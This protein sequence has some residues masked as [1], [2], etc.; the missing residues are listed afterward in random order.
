MELKMAKRKTDM[1]KQV[2]EL[3][4]LQLLLVK[5][6]N[7]YYNTAAK[8]YSMSTRMYNWVDTYNDMKSLPAWSVFRKKHG[9]DVGHDAFDNFA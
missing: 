2:A 3:E 1:E 5:N 7:A 6:Q 9:F 8:G 4:R